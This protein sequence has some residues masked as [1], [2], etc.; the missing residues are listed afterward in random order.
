MIAT[1]L[2]SILGH[3]QPRTSRRQQNLHWRLS[4]NAARLSFMQRLV[5]LSLLSFALFACEKAQ[6][7]PPEPAHQQPDDGE[8]EGREVV[9]NW[10]AKP[11][12]VTVCPLTGNKFEVDA[13]SG[14]VS[15]QGYSFVFCCSGECLVPVEADPG[16]VL[17]ALVEEAGGP[18]SDPDPAEGGAIDD[19][20]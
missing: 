7:S 5:I 17:D 1:S 13:N 6:T 4:G 9:D 11:G 12:D 15:Y 10:R 8:L 20:M 16:K 14:R 18:A 2:T 19:S 3:G